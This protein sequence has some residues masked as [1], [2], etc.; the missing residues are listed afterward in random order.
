MLLGMNARKT[1]LD[2]SATLC[3]AK[4]VRGLFGLNYY[5]RP[6]LAR[7]DARHCQ[8]AQRSVWPQ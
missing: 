8:V 5:F 4:R 3:Y 7:Q 6:F 2:L 1:S